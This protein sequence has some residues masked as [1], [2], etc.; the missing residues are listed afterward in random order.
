MFSH[1]STVISLI[2]LALVRRQFMSVQR[3]GRQ[4][5]KGPSCTFFAELLSGRFISF[6][7]IQEVEKK[8]R[9]KRTVF[10]KGQLDERVGCKE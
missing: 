4:P 8:I 3:K 1:N 9:P 2:D 6:T 10:S 5:K 7:I